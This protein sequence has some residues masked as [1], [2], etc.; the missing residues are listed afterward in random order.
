MASSVVGKLT[1]LITG[2]TTA[3]RSS[4]TKSQRTIKSL[5]KDIQQFGTR[6]T[7]N[8]TLPLA[9]A[10]VASLKFAADIETQKVAFGVLLGDVERGAELFERLKTFSAE[11]PLQLDDITRGAQTL[12]AFGTAAEDVQN[13][14]QMI[15]DVAQG[16]APKMQR[17]TEAYGKLQAK[18]RA[19]L[20][21]LNRFTENGVGIMAALA[22]QLDV[23]TEELFK[24][25]SQG[26]VTF[27]DVDAA[28]VS[29]TGTGG[30][31]E[32]MMERISQTTAGKFSTALDNVKLAAAD[33]VTVL[34]PAVNSFLD[35]VTKGA[36]AIAE[37]DNQTKRWVL[38]V[39]G[40]AAAA[41]PLLTVLGLLTKAAASNPYV[42]L[43]AAIVT[44][45]TAIILWRRATNESLQ[46]QR[47][48]N[49]AIENTTAATDEDTLAL[50]RNRRELLEQAIARDKE[51][52]SIAESLIARNLATQSAMKGGRGMGEAWKGLQKQQEGYTRELDSATAA[53]ELHNISLHEATLQVQ[54]LEGALIEGKT[55]AEE[56]TDADTDGLKER[57]VLNKALA[58]TVDDYSA[59][60]D[61]SLEPLT[62]AGKIRLAIYDAE[63]EALE[64]L[65]KKHKEA[66]ETAFAV[67]GPVFTAVGKGIIDNANAWDLFKGAAKSAIAMTIEG[68]AKQWALQA[69]AALIPSPFTFNPAAAAGFTAL[70]VSALVAAGIVRA[71]ATG[72]SF[73][74]NGPQL[75]LAGDNP[76][77]RETVD[78]TP[79]SS[80]NM[81]GPGQMIHFTFN[82]GGRTL[83]DD[84]HTATENGEL[85]IAE[86]GVR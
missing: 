56:L 17:L 33:L 67:W 24:M 44:I 79:R 40:M 46:A 66:A 36:K 3:L 58:V 49:R 18:G 78:I 6:L 61:N 53:L 50:A 54:T 21:E 64:D 22:D 57:I 55:A 48:L 68:F 85:I 59:S 20:E 12:L 51:R 32:G 5:G 62:I 15:G 47:D 16:N 26:K 8:L 34:L 74:T 11:T 10:G 30:Q 23:T 65:E 83:Y 9:A 82:L 70:S 84:I 80:P 72:G 41:G 27:E 69:A 35:L 1:Y 86:R 38:A 37:W 45:T 13:K 28:L 76:G 14:L 19:S 43:A 60:V 75:I 77:G 39:A 2:D 7:R 73:Q 29:M 71:M 63:Q 31:F 81:R 52:I 42:V 25:V 4:L